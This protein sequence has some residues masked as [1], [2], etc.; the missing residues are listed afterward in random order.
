MDVIGMNNL[1]YQVVHVTATG[2]MEGMELQWTIAA[3]A[4]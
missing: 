1:I 2:M 3:T 4:N